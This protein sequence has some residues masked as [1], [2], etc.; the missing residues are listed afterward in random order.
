MKVRTDDGV[1]LDAEFDIQEG[2]PIVLTLESRGG[3]RN[4]DYNPAL[5]LLLAR[6]GRQRAT[7]QEVLISSRDAVSKPWQDRI[8][9]MD[10]KPYPIRLTPGTDAHALRRGL[11]TAQQRTGRAPGAR[12]G[13]NP[14]KRIS[15]MLTFERA[16]EYGKLRQQL[17]H[18]GMSALPA[19]ARIVDKANSRYGINFRQPDLDAAGVRIGDYVDLKLREGVL[20]GQVRR[21]TVN[22]PEIWLAVGELEDWSYQRFTDVIRAQ[23]VEAPQE[24]TFEVLAAVE[25]PAGVTHDPEELEQRAARL[26]TPADG[27]VGT[28]RPERVV[29]ASRSF[30]RDPRVVAEVL[31][32]AEGSCELCTQPAP[33]IRVNGDPYLEVHHAQTLADGGAD[34]VDNAVALCPNCHR[35]LHHG[36]DRDEARK[37]LYQQVGRLAR[38]E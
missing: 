36:Q 5:E 8:V 26:R 35:L 31:R 23:G 22:N 28:D 25:D 4:N 32:L 17:A 1:E 12:G 18:G 19:R 21:G 33:F 3:G 10:G 20:K 9:T 29:S 16:I 11:S 13:G 7:I 24:I 2:F 34:R 6:L 37:R 30:V 38:P 14:T 27:D 15:V